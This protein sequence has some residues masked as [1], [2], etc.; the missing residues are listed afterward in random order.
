[1]KLYIVSLI[2]LLKITSKSYHYTVNIPSLILWRDCTFRW[3]VPQRQGTRC[4]N[5]WDKML[6][7]MIRLR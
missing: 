6:N 7:M 3:F 4:L 1:M 2:K 5:P